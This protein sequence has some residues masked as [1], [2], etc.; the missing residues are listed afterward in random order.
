[1]GPLV[2]PALGFTIDFYAEHRAIEYAA[3]LE[4]LGAIAAETGR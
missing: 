3:D 1:V 2:L 4:S